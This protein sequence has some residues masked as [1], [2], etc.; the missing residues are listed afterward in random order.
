MK[1][2]AKIFLMGMYLHLVLS[3]AV[4][5]GMLYF[6]DSGWNTV[7]MGLFEFY[8]AMVVI[9]HIAGWVC[10]AAAVMA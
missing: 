10:V 8:L 7:V 4:P 9:V 5:M 2:L 1:K 6:G 3:I